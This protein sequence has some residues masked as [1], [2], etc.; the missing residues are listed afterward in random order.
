MSKV[1]FLFPGQGSQSVGMLQ[2]YSDVALVR[3]T[4]TEASD[5][6]HTDI[7]ALCQTGPVSQLNQT[8][9]TQ[10]ALLTAS[11][12]LWRVWQERTDCKP[13]ILAGHSLG[14]YSALVCAQS[15]NFADAVDIVHNRGRY[16]QQAV[17][18]GVGA[19]AAIIG[20]DDAAVESLCATVSKEDAWVSAAN[21]NAPLQVVVSGH[22]QAVLVLIDA[23]KAQGA[24]IATLI[25]VS[26]PS[27]CKLMQEAAFQ[28]KCRLEE[29]TFSAPVLPVMNNVDNVIAKAPEQIREALVRQLHSPV[30][31]RTLIEK[32]AAKEVTHFVECGPKKV[33]MGLNKRIVKT[34]PTL[35]IDT[36][37]GLDEAM[38]KLV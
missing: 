29:I 28:L 2:A 1:A 25:P 13:I 34:I 11:V 4:F 17:A 23:A 19:M 31:W 12:A 6:L 36:P 7:W 20:L 26:V 32:L 35:L 33:L 8:E 14:E 37:E 27:H 16:M 10:P 18:E 30:R 24:K 38:E 21:Y 15:M 3:D 22:R 5:I 9:F